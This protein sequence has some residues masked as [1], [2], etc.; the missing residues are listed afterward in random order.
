MLCKTTP[1]QSHK[2]VVRSI[3]NATTLN[4]QGLQR[5]IYYGDSR[6]KW[7]LDQDWIIEK[8]K[9]KPLELKVD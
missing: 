1:Y 7:L 3:K 4:L 6:M 5:Y 2:I 9:C 8:G